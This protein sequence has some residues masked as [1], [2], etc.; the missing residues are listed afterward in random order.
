MILIIVVWHLQVGHAEESETEVLLG[1]QQ[2][3]MT[4][5][6]LA[7]VSKQAGRTGKGLRVMKL[8]DGDN[9]VTVTPVFAQAGML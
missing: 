2:G 3:L 6:S 8:N 1:S 5:I 4:R 9:I 7:D